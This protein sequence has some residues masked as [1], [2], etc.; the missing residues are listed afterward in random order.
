MQPLSVYVVALGIYVG[1]GGSGNVVGVS[2]DTTLDANRETMRKETET[3]VL[4][5][6]VGFV[7]FEG[8]VHEHFDEYIRSSCSGPGY[9]GLGGS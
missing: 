5:S 9:G 6:C 4:S 1:G 2:C 3:V 7:S 8:L